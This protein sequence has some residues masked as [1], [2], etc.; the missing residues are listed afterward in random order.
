MDCAK[1]FVKNSLILE[2]FETPFPD[3]IETDPFYFKNLEKAI[4][5]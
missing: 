1:V 5:S 4:N 3:K 2:D